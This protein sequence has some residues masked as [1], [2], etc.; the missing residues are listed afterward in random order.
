MHVE[1][2]WYGSRPADRAARWALWPLSAL[3][4]FGWNVY[5][6]AYRVGFKR[7][8]SPHRPVVCIG[9][10]IVGGSGKTPVT[11][12]I[13]RVLLDAGVPLAV[14]LSGYGAPRSEA[15]TLAPEGELDPAEWGDEPAMFRELL[16]SVPLIVGRRR[17]LAAEIC[18]RQ[19]PTHALVM[20]DGFQHLPLRKHLTLLLDPE[21]PNRWCLPAGPY[22]EPQRSRDRADLVLPGAFRV[23]EQPLRWTDGDGMPAELPAAYDVLCALGAPSGFL[24]ALPA[25]PV[26]LELR[27]DHDPLTQGNLLSCFTGELAI[28]VTAKDWVKL[29]RR[30][31]AHKFSWRIAHKEV[32]IEPADVFRGWLLQNLARVTAE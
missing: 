1:S 28:A 10:L 23:V 24:A 17:V 19:M 20:D 32:T 22:R 7:A 31:D 9:N 11:L 6:T 8:K 5:R 12:H 14:S 29:R 3:Y 4:A 26:T 16:P 25:H 27:P 15:A 21:R 13:A 30:P 18:S 2:I